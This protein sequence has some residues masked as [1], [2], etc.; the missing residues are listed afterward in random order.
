MKIK[1][2]EDSVINSGMQSCMEGVLKK[3]NTL[4]KIKSDTKLPFYGI[5]GKDFKRMWLPHKS[6]NECEFWRSILQK[7]FIHNENLNS[8]VLWQICRGTSEKSII[9]FVSDIKYIHTAET[10]ERK[11]LNIIQSP[12]IYIDKEEI[13]NVDK[14]IYEFALCHNLIL[15]ETYYLSNRVEAVKTLNSSDNEYGYFK[16]FINS[17]LTLRLMYEFNK[18]KAMEV[19]KHSDQLAGSWKIPLLKLKNI[20]QKRLK[21]VIKNGD[22]VNCEYKVIDGTA[23][24]SYGNDLRKILQ[25]IDFEFP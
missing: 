11:G 18:E 20:E 5:E 22:I 9:A 2:S 10:A 1:C 19:M 15:A 25:D 24:E 13:R 4:L 7:D 14:S 6:E 23:D 8:E 3:Y 17:F 16:S 21:T 12:G